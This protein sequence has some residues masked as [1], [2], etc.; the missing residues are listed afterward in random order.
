MKRLIRSQKKMSKKPTGTLR[1][2]L[3]EQT[4]GPMTSKHGRKHYGRNDRRQA[5]QKMRQEE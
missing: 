3:P 1:L 2:P 5:K 4:G